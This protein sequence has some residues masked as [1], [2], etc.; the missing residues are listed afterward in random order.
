MHFIF[1]LALALS[2]ILVLSHAHAASLE[3]RYIAARDAAIAKFAKQ[4]K[5]GKTGEA[6]DKAEAAARDELKTQLTAILSESAWPG[7]APAQLNLDTLYNGDMGFGMLDG[8][9]FDADKGRDGG[10]IGWQRPDGSFVE[11][12][13]HIIVTTEALFTR[14]LHEH[15]TWWDKG[16]KNVPQQIEAALKFEGLYT[17]AISTDAAV[18]NFDQLPVA[19]PSPATLTYGFLAGRTQDSTPEAG[20]EV[21]VAALAGGK[22]YIA[23]GEIE[24][25][26]QVPTCATIRADY[27][28]KADA[29]AEKLDRKEITKKAYDKLGDLRQQGDDAFKRCFVQHAPEQPAFAEAT[30]QAQ[31]LLQTAIGR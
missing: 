28:K 22:F 11:P 2:P 29:A 7:F 12:K 17:Q 3:D 18:I 26:V 19:K 15:K 6:V 14:W 31:A 16:S 9:R 1:R 21:F 20:D 5:D 24:P 4:A 13:A 27:N 30:K 10:K 25:A 8:L 23:C